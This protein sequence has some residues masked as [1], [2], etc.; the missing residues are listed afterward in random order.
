MDLDKLLYLQGV[1]NS[2]VDC[3]GIYHEISMED[4]E[5]LLRTMC[6][7]QLA[8]YE[9]S[10]N[11]DGFAT[12]VET[13]IDELD[14]RP[15]RSLL[16]PFQWT[17]AQ[18]PLITFQV[19]A[20]FG[21][22]LL[23]TF[24]DEVNGLSSFSFSAQRA[25]VSG[26]YFTQNRAYV[27]RRYSLQQLF[28]DAGLECPGAGYHHLKLAIQDEPESTV[29][30]TLVIAPE[31]VYG[32]DITAIVP[33]RRPW[34]IS[35]QV[36][37]LW[38]PSAD[39]KLPTTFGDFATLSTTISRFAEQ[40]ADFLLL[41][42][43]HALPLHSPEDAS[44]YSPYDRRRINPLYI[45]AQ[46][47]SEGKDPKWATHLPKRMP[48]LDAGGDWIDYPAAA[49]VKAAELKALYKVFCGYAKTAPRRIAFDAFVS[50]QGVALTQYAEQQA[51]Q[52]QAPWLKNTEFY[53]Y[54][55]FVAEE[56]L[57][58]C[59]QQAL[60][61]G[62][63]IGLVR[64]MAVGAVGGGVEVAQAGEQF[65]TRA[66]IGAPPDPFAPQG[67]NWGLTPLDPVGLKQHNFGHFIELLRSNMRH[68]GALRIDHF[69][70]LFRIWWWP[71]A[72]AGE[73]QPS[74]SYIYYPFEAMMAILRLESHRARCM[75]IG[76]DLGIVPPEI[77]QPMFAAGIYSNE[78]FYFCSDE[79]QFP[80]YAGYK[81]PNDYKQH[82][83]MMLANH[84]VPTMA[85]WWQGKDLLIREQLQLLKQGE[86]EQLQQRREYHRQ[87]I[88][89]WLAEI[90]HCDVSDT[91]FTHLLPSWAGA[92][93]AGR[94]QLYSVALADLLAEEDA[95][96]IPG[97]SSEYPNW[98]RRY[99]QS[100]T[101]FSQNELLHRVLAAIRSARSTQI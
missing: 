18:H 83:L 46:M 63:K 47:S 49:K 37:S 93:A 23:L 64:D 27:E 89:R 11:S 9:T 19:L 6:A 13:R 24:D 57:A 32:A 5:H 54:L 73:S 41:N 48:K 31:Q 78:L 59:Q 95:I 36:F 33:E 51:V 42:P 34:G 12:W 91:H 53:L 62:M 101:E 14:A 94:S 65:C 17:N 26:D 29:E 71:L 81:H 75:V 7:N 38:Q 22:E 67:Q 39:G 30:G 69:M 88:L 97:T 87:G 28:T 16:R 85:A 77:K 86:L 1:G 21:G 61:Q 68:C 80:Q 74:G 15:W 35:L 90:A 84:D 100:V 10:A 60:Q 45:A 70:G 4:R 43:L 58:H 8:Q 52:A 20:E 55:Q 66:S 96:N 79:Y 2:F 44:P 76:E 99:S 72:A 3:D 82:S 92:V 56:Q 40:G 25:E 98:R 50:E